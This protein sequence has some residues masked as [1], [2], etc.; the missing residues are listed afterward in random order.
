MTQYRFH[1]IVVSSARY[2]VWLPHSANASGLGGIEG[3]DLNALIVQPPRK[4]ALGTLGVTR[5][6]THEGDPRRQTYGTRMDE[7]HHHPYQGIHMA[8]IKPLPVLTHQLHQLTIQ[9]RGFSIGT[10]F[11]K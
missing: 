9:P 7:A 10:P 1:N 2:S 11:L 8:D 4:A 5:P 3:L 6:T